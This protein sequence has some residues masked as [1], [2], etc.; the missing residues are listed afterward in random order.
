M[1]CERIAVTDLLFGRLVRGASSRGESARSEQCE[2]ENGTPPSRSGRPSPNDPAACNLT[3]G[4]GSRQN[5]IRFE[6]RHPLMV[7][8]P[9]LGCSDVST[10]KEARAMVLFSSH[11]NAGCLRCIADS[12]F[13]RFPAFRWESV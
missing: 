3:D 7:P 8:T 10:V 2:T 5:L 4:D 6:Q 11:L 12:R 1:T 13:P 9:R